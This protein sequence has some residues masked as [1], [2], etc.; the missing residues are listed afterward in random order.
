V[1]RE[2]RARLR[3]RL[4]YTQPQKASAP[5]GFDP[6]REQLD[7]ITRHQHCR[8]TKPCH[9]GSTSKIRDLPRHAPHTLS[10]CS[11]RQSCQGGMLRCAPPFR[12][13]CAARRDALNASAPGEMSPFCLTRGKSISSTQPSRYACK[14]EAAF[15]GI[16]FFM[17]AITL[18]PL[19]ALEDGAV[20]SLNARTEYCPRRNAQYSGARHLPSISPSS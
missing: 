20:Q 2:W 9:T 8:S 19:L 18:S 1:D 17:R 3:R 7:L 6:C 14:K 12:V 13:T 10:L 4:S 11:L 15:Y 5:S 16:S